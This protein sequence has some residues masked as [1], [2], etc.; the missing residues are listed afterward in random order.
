MGREFVRSFLLPQFFLT[1][2]EPLSDE[3]RRAI[4]EARSNLARFA[5]NS[6][7]LYYPHSSS[8]K[9]REH[10]QN[11]TRLIEIF[12]ARSTELTAQD[13]ADQL[14]L[15]RTTIYRNLAPQIQD[16]ETVKVELAGRVYEVRREKKKGV[17]YYQLNPN[18][19]ISS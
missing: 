15:S 6:A 9:I 16:S 5:T 4:N 13:L 12:L 3:Q 14:E 11:L 7:E 8:K 10:A 18:P 1:A 17:W 2:G 19:N